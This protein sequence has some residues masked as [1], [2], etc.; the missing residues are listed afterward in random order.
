MRQER[1][2]FFTEK[3]E[4]FISLLIAAG[5]RKN[6]ALVIVFLANTPEGSSREIERGTDLRQPDVSLAIKF[7]TERGWIRVRDIL[8]A[9]KGR[10]TKIYALAMPLSGIVDGIWKE[11]VDEL[12]THL[13]YVQKMK[14]YL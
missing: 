2:Q 7:L 9:H 11:K 5:T 8:V 6:I 1:V 3:E 12:K 4:E 10:P 13:A 14:E